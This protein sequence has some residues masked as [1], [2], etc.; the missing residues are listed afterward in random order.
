MPGALERDENAPL[1]DV[2]ASAFWF[3]TAAEE[4]STVSE[5]FLKKPGQALDFQAHYT[6]IPELTKGDFKVP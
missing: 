6:T 4:A 1:E 5:F 2:N 3:L